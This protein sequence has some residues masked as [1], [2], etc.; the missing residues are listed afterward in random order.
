M[1]I[2]SI[3]LVNECFYAIILNMSA[4]LITHNLLFLLGGVSNVAVAMFVLVSSRKNITP[5]V[6]TFVLL[7]IA[8]ATFQISHLIGVNMPD[9]ESS[10]MVLMFHLS[11]NFIMMF[12]PHW[13]L[14][15]TGKV[16]EKIVQLWVVY[17]SGI[18]LVIYC[19][20]NPKMYLLT[21]VPKMY[22]PYY[23]EP[24]PMYIVMTIWFFAVGT[25]FFYLLNNALKTQTDPTEKNRLKYVLY[26]T[27]FAFITGTT[28]ILLVFNVQFDP[29]WSA[30]FSLYTVPLAYAII[31]Y[32]LLDIRII[33]RRAIAYLVTMVLLGIGIGATNLAGNYLQYAEPGFPTWIMPVLLAILI[34]ESGIY[35]WQKAREEDLAKYEFVNLVTHKFRGPLTDIKWALD[36]IKTEKMCV[37]EGGQHY[38]E[39]LEEANSKMVELTNALAD[40]NEADNRKFSYHYSTF[41]LVDA[42]KAVAEDYRER[43]AVKKIEFGIYSTG[44]DTTVYG[45][46]EKIKLVADIL[47]NNAL[48]YTASG[49]RVTVRF[50]PRG[51]Y[52][53]M[54]I[55]DTGI[56]IA[57]ADSPFMFRKF[58]R[59]ENAKKITVNG[60]GIGLYLANE[61]VKRNGGTLSFFSQ[62]DE[63]GSTFAVRLPILI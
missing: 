30:L 9:G 10:R 37:S 39:T 58:Y 33:A 54:T 61:I 56:G 34:S 45:D 6:T 20:F 41:P 42:V 35:V 62:G 7:S 15:L 60:T 59:S 31:R 22:F 2:R 16:K 18:S 28:M 12:M 23:Y 1:F 27:I 21:S 44:V 63:K 5:S 29:V 36:I 8:V 40:L 32:E 47:I 52:L 55:N 24:G 46:I 53:E 48:A 38:L 26:S 50:W 4:S 11:T 13:F 51:K 25:Y 3:H 19:I 49:G 17:I 14:A 57:D 43:F